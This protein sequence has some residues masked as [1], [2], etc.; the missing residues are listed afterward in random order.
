MKVQIMQ[1]NIEKKCSPLS[2]SIFFYVQHF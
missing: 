2:C 1:L